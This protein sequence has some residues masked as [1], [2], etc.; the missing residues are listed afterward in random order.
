[1]HGP[2]ASASSGAGSPSTTPYEGP[3]TCVHGGVIAELFDELL[4]IS[5]ILAG[6]GAMTGTLTIRYRR[7]TPL[8][9]LSSWRRGI[10]EPSGAR[11]SPGA[12]C[13]TRV[14]SRRR[15]RACSS[16]PPAHAR[17]RDR[18]R[19][20]RAQRGGPTGRRR[21]AAHDGQGRARRGEED[22]GLTREGRA[23]P[24]AKGAESVEGFVPRRRHLSHCIAR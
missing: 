13:T 1:M 24:I 4:G 8:L 19:P 3:P 18:Q 17:H 22:P 7:P 15:P 6:P 14:S 16:G 10:R 5:N 2:T 9:A 23:I 12:A 11:C 21:L 20:R